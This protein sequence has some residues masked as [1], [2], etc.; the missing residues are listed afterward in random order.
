VKQEIKYLQ[1]NRQ[2]V[3]EK[4]AGEQVTEEETLAVVEG[5]GEKHLLE[6]SEPGEE[7]LSGEQGNGGRAFRRT[8]R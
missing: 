1:E 7:T 3:K 4:L 2:L 5:K 8:Q 6:T